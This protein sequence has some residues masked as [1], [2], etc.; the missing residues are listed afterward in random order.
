[1]GLGMHRWY[2]MAIVVCRRLEN[3]IEGFVNAVDSFPFIWLDDFQV[4]R[5]AH[6][7]GG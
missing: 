5:I 3:G 4:G 7:R 1:M 2:R 6:G